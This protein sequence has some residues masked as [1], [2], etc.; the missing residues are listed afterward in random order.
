M[1]WLI[2]TPNQ[3][4]SDGNK[5]GAD[6]K[7]Q[8]D[9]P[10]VQVG[11]NADATN[12]GL[13]NDSKPKTKRRPNH[14]ATL[15]LAASHDCDEGEQRDDDQH[16]GQQAIGEL[17]KPVDSLLGN[18]CERIIR[19]FRPGGAAQARSGKPNGTAGHDDEYL[20]S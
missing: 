7:V 17:D 20:A 19:A 4:R 8:A 10:R 13:R 2:E 12:D 15:R 6:N 9:N 1:L 11:E 14:A 3:N 18:I 5:N 16:E